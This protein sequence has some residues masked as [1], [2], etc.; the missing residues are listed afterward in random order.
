M[1]RGLRGKGCVKG[2]EGERDVWRGLRGKVCVK[3]IEGKGCVEGIE[4]KWLWGG[5]R[6]V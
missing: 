4:G 3:G 5:E 1:W 2:I 6:D